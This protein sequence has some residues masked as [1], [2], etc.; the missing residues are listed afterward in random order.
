MQRLDIRTYVG[1]PGELAFIDTTV[2]GGGAVQFR[3]DGAPVPGAD[4]NFP[5]KPNAGDELL[6]DLALIGANG[7]SCT[8]GIRDA[9]NLLDGD[10]LLVQALDPLPTHRYRFLT[11]SAIA[12][13]AIRGLNLVEN[14]PRPRP[15]KKAAKKKAKN[16]KPTAK[17]GV[18]S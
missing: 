14:A 13:T 17:K 16:K 18:A 7:E 10:F 1:Q 12:L 2:Q 3:I 4:I 6:V 5:L 15:A 9:N 11:A 8:V